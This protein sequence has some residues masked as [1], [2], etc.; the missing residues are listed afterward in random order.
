MSF[1]LD[2]I[3]QSLRNVWIMNCIQVLLGIGIS[4][5]PSVFAYS[6]LYPYTDNFLDAGKVSERQK[7]ETNDRLEKRL[8]GEP[9]RSETLLENRLFKLVEMIEGQFDRKLFP[10]VYRSLIG[11][12][13]AQVRSMRQDKGS[14]LSLRK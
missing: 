10:M 3:F 6:M 2:D 14:P 11:I 13:A 7:R 4:V 8:G 9:V 1:R 12:H 5:T